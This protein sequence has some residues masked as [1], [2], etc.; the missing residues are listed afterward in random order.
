MIGVGMNDVEA[1][2]V[3]L[4]PQPKRR[5]HIECPFWPNHRKAADDDAVEHFAAW[6][7]ACRVGGDDL[8]G[9]PASG[10]P[11]SQ[12]ADVALDPA[13]RRRI[14]RCNQGN[15]SGLERHAGTLTTSRLPG[16][17][18]NSSSKQAAVSAQE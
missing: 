16:S 13:D 14:A 9:V 6:Q 2:G 12:H 18:A 15:G 8:D 3:A 5:G 1:P 4:K 11:L 17:I 7:L 10:E